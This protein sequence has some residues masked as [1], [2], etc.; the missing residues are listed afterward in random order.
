MHELTAPITRVTVAEDRAFVRRQGLLL[1]PPGLSRWRLEGVSPVIVDKSLNLQ[2]DGSIRVV[3][4]QVLRHK[5]EEALASPPARAEQPDS[6]LELELLQDEIRSAEALYQELLMMIEEQA[7]WGTAAP[8]EWERQLC[9]ILEW[10]DQLEQRHL[11][12]LRPA[13][14]RPHVFPVHHTGSRRTE[15]LIDLESQGGDELQLTLEYCVPLAAWRPYHQAEWLGDRVQFYAEGCVWQ[16]TGE[17]WNEVELVLSTER[18]SLGVVPPPLPED[19]LNTRKRNGEIRLQQREV[20]VSNLP[21]SPPHEIPGID[22]GG[23]LFSLAVP[24]RCTLPSDG[25]AV[26][27]QLFDFSSPASMKN[28]LA[29]EVSTQVVQLTQLQNLS[30]W[31]LLAGPV[32][33]LREA[34]WVGRTRLGLVAPG[35]GFGLSWGPQPNLRASRSTRQG[36]P[37]KDDLLGGWSRTRTQTSV[38]LSNLSAE[39]Q[40]VEV[41]ERIPVSEIKQVQVHLEGDLKA[42]ENGFL[43]WNL[44]LGPRSKRVVELAFWMRRRKNVV[45]S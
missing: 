26:R 1:L 39:T 20:Q 45:A 42:D 27:V 18:Q 6:S 8:E 19:Y 37:E 29:A 13:E 33:L 14:V 38:T 7:A 5:A 10:K 25:Q 41:L 43:R 11:G 28:L 12:L 21:L 34:G 36:T 15:V 9:E 31:P 32:D 16:N 23:Q 40:C 4:T 3:S 35:E 24:G 44:E 22:D 17:D 2:V 30:R